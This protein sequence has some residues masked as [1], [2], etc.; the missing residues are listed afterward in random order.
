MIR[1]GDGAGGLVAG[2]FVFGARLVLSVEC[3]LHFSVFD[4]IWSKWAAVW[5]SEACT[6]K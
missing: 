5:D 3:V 1:V 4:A 6:S 2:R